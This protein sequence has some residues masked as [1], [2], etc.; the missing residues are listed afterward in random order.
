VGT[1]ANATPPELIINHPIAI[2]AE[3]REANVE[4]HN[5]HEEWQKDEQ[6]EWLMPHKQ[7]DSEE[8]A[9]NETCSDREATMPKT[10]LVGR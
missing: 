7:R 9:E 1:K 2:V 4:P 8:S 10:L 6:G 3:V 5:Q